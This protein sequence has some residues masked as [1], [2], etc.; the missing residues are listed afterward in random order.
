MVQ[1]LPHLK[2]DLGTIYT[3]VHSPIAHVFTIAGLRSLSQG[4]HRPVTPFVCQRLAE[5]CVRFACV[6]WLI[7]DVGQ[8]VATASFRDVR[9]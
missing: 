1:I 7:A 5:V 4:L 9:S 6:D 8:T 2:V 3:R